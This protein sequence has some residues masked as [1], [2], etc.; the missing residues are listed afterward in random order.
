M[1]LKASEEHAVQPHI[2]AQQRIKKFV[3]GHGLR[4]RQHTL[5]WL[6]NLDLEEKAIML[7]KEFSRCEEHCHELASTER[8]IVAKSLCS[9]IGLGPLSTFLRACLIQTVRHYVKC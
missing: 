7:L 1:N 2:V 3:H 9:S 5:L 4:N 8:E 6:S